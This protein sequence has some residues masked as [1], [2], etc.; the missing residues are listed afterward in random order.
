MTCR[1]PHHEQVQQRVALVLV[2]LVVPVVG[3]VVYE[4]HH[5]EAHG[6]QPQHAGLLQEVVDA[7]AACDSVAGHL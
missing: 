2:L 5:A 4:L 3:Q 7:L 6:Q 1:R